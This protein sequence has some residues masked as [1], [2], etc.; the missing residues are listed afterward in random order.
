MSMESS[1]LNLGPLCQLCAD[2]V[3]AE[4]T[5]FR[6][7]ASAFISLESL[8]GNKGKKEGEE[9]DKDTSVASCHH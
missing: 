8:M 3:S 1:L 6:S 9:V 2:V 5:K 4:K 7:P